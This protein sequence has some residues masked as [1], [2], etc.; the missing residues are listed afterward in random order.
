[1]IEVKIKEQ[2]R[3][4][5][6]AAFFLKVDSVALVLGNC[7]HLWN[8]SR[9][10]FLKNSRWYRHELAHIRQFIQYGY[11]TFLLKYVSESIRKGYKKNCF[12]IEARQ[13]ENDLNMEI[14]IRL[15]N[16]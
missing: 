6:I 9:N 8:V 7:I 14:D 3:L 15:L 16:T 13:K 11:Y 5:A 1:M 12:E 2:S 4:A 10:D